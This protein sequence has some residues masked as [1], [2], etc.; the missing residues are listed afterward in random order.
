MAV[1]GNGWPVSPVQSELGIETMMIGGVPFPVRGGKVRE[2]L[3]YVATQ[4]HNR[5]EKANATYGCWGYSYRMNVNSPGSWSNHASGTAIDF[6]ATRHPNGVP[7]AATFSAAQIAE[8]HAILAEVG[9][10]VRWGGDYSGTPDAMHFEIN[11]GPEALD[12][13]IETNEIPTNGEIK[14]IGAPTLADPTKLPRLTENSVSYPT[15][16]N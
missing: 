16:M 15:M 13:A 9:G 14:P 11:V 6:N 7:T 12:V 3:E 4:V 5:V 1:S 10:V 8:I 2:A